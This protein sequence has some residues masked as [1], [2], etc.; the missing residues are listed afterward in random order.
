MK[1]VL[2]SD[3]IRSEKERKVQTMKRY[4]VYMYNNIEK[5]HDCYMVIAEDPVDARNIAVQRLVEETGH[6]L[7]RYEIMKVKV[8]DRND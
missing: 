7:D 4:N 3:I 2:T 1:K 6:G 5:F 8:V